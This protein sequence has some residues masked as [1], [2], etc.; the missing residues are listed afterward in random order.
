MPG[1]LGDIFSRFPREPKSR[2]TGEGDPVAEFRKRYQTFTEQ[3]GAVPQGAVFEAAAIGPV[4]GE[5]TRT[6]NASPERLI[7]YFHGGGYVAGSPE[8]HRALVARLAQASEAVVFSPAYRLAPEYAFPA[9][10][11]DGIDVYRQLV[12]HGIAPQ[13]IVL[14]GDGAGGGLALAVL[15]AVRNADLPLPAALFAMSPWADMA[16]SGW[17]IL[18]NGASDGAFSWEELFVSARSYLGRSNPADPYASPAFANF[19]DFPPLMVHAG[20][21]ELLRDDASRIGDRAAEAGIPVS[22]EVYDGMRH[23]FQADTRLPE[24][25]VSL[26]RLGQ[27]VRARIQAAAEAELSAEPAEEE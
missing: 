26:Q 24:A 22:I 2:A 17:S 21:L 7:L 18:Q 20:S 9:A 14:G 16:L 3:F 4:K 25:K 12:S 23:L 1:W 11:R 13:S 6:E 19:K 10:V 8:S 5:W 15:L 27:F